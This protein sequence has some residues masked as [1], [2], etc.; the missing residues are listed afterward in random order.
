MLLSFALM[1]ALIQPPVAAPPP[2]GVD[3]GAQARQA[4]SLFRFRSGFWSNLHHFLYV[5]GRDRNRAPDRARDAVVNAP[6]DVEGLSA[7]S[8]AARTAWEAAI[9]AY[10]AG[11][12]KKDAI[13]DRDLVA[14][15]RAL[16][17]APD[18]SDLSGLALDPAVVSALRQAAPVYR[19]VWWPRHARGNAARRAELEKMIDLYG[20][21]A[22]ARLTGLYGTRWPPTP[23]TIDLC[24]YTNWAGAYS[25]D[26]GLIAVS[27][28]DEAL[29][30][31]EGLETLLHEAS[32]QWDEDVERRLSAIASK[33]GRPVPRSL[34]HALIFYTSGEIVLELIPGHVPYATRFGVWDRGMSDLKPL[35]DT[36]WRPY[37][38][39]T[40]TFDEAIAAILAAH[41]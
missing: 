8:E 5:L 28:T 10:A 41:R 27:S 25:T 34:S 1:A 37:V 15:T 13:F 29:S 12:S 24:A 16:A 19:A 32:H 36:Y 17:D 11:P 3:R 6:K 21:R 18:D 7:Q 40:V 33:A 23:Q 39:G 38:R 35:L 14:M 22:V 30:G 4:A 31:S 26:G 2:A 20:V 9:G